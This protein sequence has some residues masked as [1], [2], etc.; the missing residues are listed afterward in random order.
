MAM[1]E[2]AF[3]ASTL[4]VRARCCKKGWHAL[5][6]GLQG[7]SSSRLQ[8]V[9]ANIPAEILSFE[10]DTPRIGSCLLQGVEQRILQCGNCDYTATGRFNHVVFG[11]GSRME[12]NRF[13]YAFDVADGFSRFIGAGIT[14]RHQYHGS[15]GF[16]RKGE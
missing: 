13:L 15:G 6:R 8:Q 5:P 3:S 9:K 11:G 2:K 1:R 12:N 7:S 14:T 4:L 16:W 10:V